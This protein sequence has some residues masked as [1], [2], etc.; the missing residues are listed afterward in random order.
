MND[1][2]PTPFNIGA[3]FGKFRLLINIRHDLYPPNEF[4]SI[5]RT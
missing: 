1:R 5:R 4:S 3:S 2:I